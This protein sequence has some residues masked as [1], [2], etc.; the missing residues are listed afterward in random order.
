MLVYFVE[1]MLMP[2]CPTSLYPGLLEIEKT[3]ST[4]TNTDSQA[5]YCSNTANGYR[6]DVA[7]LQILRLHHTEP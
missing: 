2:I 7:G 4:P 3:I 1:P 5:C 6:P